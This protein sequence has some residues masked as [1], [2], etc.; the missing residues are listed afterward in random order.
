MPS[1]RR[2]RGEEPALDDSENIGSAPAGGA[3]SAGGAGGELAEDF[4]DARRGVVWPAATNYGEDEGDKRTKKRVT[5]RAMT[6]SLRHQLSASARYH[7]SM[8]RR[9]A[10]EKGRLV[11]TSTAVGS[12]RMT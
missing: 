3:D 9:M 10:W 12:P 6:T 7:Q 5:R 2:G 8:R 1:R 4:D 11:G